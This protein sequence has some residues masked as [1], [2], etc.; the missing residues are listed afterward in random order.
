MDQI[1][2]PRELGEGEEVEF[3]VRLNRASSASPAPD[4]LRIDLEA[5]VTAA[6][7]VAEET[8]TAM[9]LPRQVIYVPPQGCDVVF[10]YRFDP[11]NANNKERK[12]GT[13]ERTLTLTASY[14]EGRKMHRKS[15]TQRFTVRLNSE[16]IIRRVGNLGNILGLTPRSMR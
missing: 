15:R 12:A 14:R 8:E 5:V 4:E 10:R 3:R 2:G 1:V 13:L 11:V 6:R 16:R 7:P 9:T